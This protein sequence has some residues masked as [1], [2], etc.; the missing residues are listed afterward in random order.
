MLVIIHQV[1][2]G[3]AA[4][5]VPGEDKGWM[6]ADSW[7]KWNIPGKPELPAV[8]R[9]RFTHV[10]CYMSVWPSHHASL[11]ASWCSLWVGVK[12]PGK[13]ELLSWRI[14]AVKRRHWVL[15]ELR[16]QWYLFLTSALGYMT[17]FCPSPAGL[18]A[19]VRAAK[20]RPLLA[21]PA[22]SGDHVVHRI[23]I[24]SCTS[25]VLP[26]CFTRQ[27]WRPVC[28]H[29]LFWYAESESWI[30]PLLLWILSLLRVPE[31]ICQLWKS[32]FGKRVCKERMLLISIS[33]SLRSS[34]HFSAWQPG[35]GSDLCLLFCFNRHLM[36]PPTVVV[37][38][39]MREIGIYHLCPAMRMKSGGLRGHLFS[40][41]DSVPR[42]QPAI[43]LVLRFQ[44]I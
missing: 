22:L 38:K 31:C 44:D 40:F 27:G 34:N 25:F 18:E 20:S 26:S 24:C 36:R 12:A 8:P 33:K 19:A 5:A 10:L 35:Y 3:M 14:W 4:F 32:E 21:N 15:M 13:L 41:R 39:D 2:K 37:Q 9:V 7:Q 29:G 43:T 1:W 17:Y 42:A 6:G 30:F 11:P 23:A 16:V 28:K